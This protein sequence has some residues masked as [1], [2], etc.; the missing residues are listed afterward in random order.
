MKMSSVCSPASRDYMIHGLYACK[1]KLIRFPSMCAFT[2]EFPN[3]SDFQFP[4]RQPSLIFNLGPHIVHACHPQ[5]GVIS[6]FLRCMQSN[7]PE[8]A[9][10][11]TTTIWCNILQ[12]GFSGLPQI[13][14]NHNQVSY[15]TNGVFPNMMSTCQHSRTWW[16]VSKSFVFPI[17]RGA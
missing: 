13:S 9:M 12:S 7:A 4:P 15:I 16:R 14:V 2:S 11:R 17:S 3:V 6:T 10:Q 1:L 8:S 5:F